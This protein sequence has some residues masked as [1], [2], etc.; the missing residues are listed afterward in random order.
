VDTNE[1]TFAAAFP[2]S[3]V[4]F[5]AGWYTEKVSGPFTW[6][7][8]QFMP[9]AFAYHLHSFSAAKL[10]TP[11]EHWAG[12]ML[13]RG[14]AATVGYVAEPYLVGTLDVGAFAVRWVQGGFSYG[15]A[16][17]AAIPVLSWQTVVVGDPLY[18]PFRRHPPEA[19]L[20]VRFQELHGELSSKT[21]AMLEWSHVQV[22]HLAAKA[23]AGVDQSELL[24]YVRNQAE[25]LQSP[26]L[27]ERQAELLLASGRIRPAIEAYQRSLRWGGSEG[28]RLRIMLA[29]GPLLEAYTRDEDALTVYDQLLEA[30]PDYPGR[31]NIQNQAATIARRLGRDES[32]QRLMETP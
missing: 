8:A 16:V 7:A 11:T 9:G 32:V 29:L 1:A 22:A 20:G 31:T 26:V 17:Y 15:E 2:M 10:R 21:N 23:A 19:P 5:Y 28:Q 18:R 12:P 6:K 13:A 3:D 14:A 30:Y 4:A 24:S 27:A 25:E